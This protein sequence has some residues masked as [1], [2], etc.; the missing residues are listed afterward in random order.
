[1]SSFLPC[2]L[3]QIDVVD[4]RS[5]LQ[6]S[7]NAFTT[8]RGLYVPH[9]DVLIFS[10]AC[11]VTFS[12]LY[13]QLNTINIAVDKFFM[14]FSLDQIHYLG[15]IQPGIHFC[16]Y[17]FE[18]LHL[19]LARIGQASK[20]PEECVRLNHDLVRNGVFNI[21]DLDGII[22][23]PVSRPIHIYVC[24]MRPVFYIHFPPHIGHNLFQ[25]IRSFDSPFPSR[26]PTPI[27]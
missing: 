22:L 4:P 3:S 6:G 21:K 18:D 12:L 9:G 25:Q 15:H 5:G 10:L 17:S 20:V 16:C 26:R 2:K 11:V 27:T 14:L 1:M 19:H 24:S 13:S 7:Y 8:K 23:R